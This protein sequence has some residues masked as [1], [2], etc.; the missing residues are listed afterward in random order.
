HGPRAFGRRE[1]MVFL[2]REISETKNYSEYYAE[3][4]DN[5]VRELVDEAYR[6][7][8]DTLTS[9]RETL[10]RVA[11]ALMER[12]TIEGAELKA[13]LN[14]ASSPALPEPTPSGS[15]PAPYPSPSL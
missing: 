12:E 11:Q 3:Q 4:I 2:G 10:D 9:H 15:T 5:E 1:E 14:G 13:L 8:L 7:A 6:R